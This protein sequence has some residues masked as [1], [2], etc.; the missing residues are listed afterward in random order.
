[1]KKHPGSVVTF[2]HALWISPRPTILSIAW[3]IFEMRSVPCKLVNYL[4]ICM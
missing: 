3:R 1:M 2:T 4:G